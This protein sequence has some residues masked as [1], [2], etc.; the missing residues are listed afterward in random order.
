MQTVK[1]RTK[2][3][4]EIKKLIGSAEIS[5]QDELLQKLEKKGYKFTQATLSRDLKFLNVGRMPHPGKGLVYVLPESASVNALS[6]TEEQAMANG[7]LSIEFSH[8]LGVIKTVP[9][10]A[11][12]LAVTIDHRKPYEIIGTVA[13]D[14][15]ILIIGREG[16]RKS[17]IVKSLSLIIPDIE[18]NF[19]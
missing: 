17:D 6:S 12:S 19:R 4:T 8:N 13:G 2:R 5:S 16:V 14:D 7:F 1:E 18:R 15:T 3:L 10:F 9:G 11:N